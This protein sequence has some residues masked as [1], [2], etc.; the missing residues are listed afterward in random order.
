MQQCL[1]MNTKAV[2]IVAV[3]L[4][5]PIGLA[6][7]DTKPRKDAPSVPWQKSATITKIARNN[8]DRK[9]IASEVQAVVSS[10]QK[11]AY[12]P[13]NMA[14][15]MQLKTPALKRLFPKHRFYLIGWD[16]VAADPKSAVPIAFGL[17]FTLVV[18]PQGE[19]IK[20]FGYGNYEDFGSLLHLN[21]VKLKSTEDADLIWTAFNDIHQKKWFDQRKHRQISPT[22]WALSEQQIDNYK[23]WYH[24][25]LDADQ[26]VTAAKLMS[27]D[28]KKP[29][30]SKFGFGR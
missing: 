17:Y 18:P 19:A 2:I 8:P 3:I 5:A 27:E 25:T 20:L 28:T 26:V 30:V 11:P 22:E 14:E 12:A 13:P 21:G 10:Y 9:L 1:T 16:M 7:A 4:F 29:A 24:I 15:P 23:Y 6:G